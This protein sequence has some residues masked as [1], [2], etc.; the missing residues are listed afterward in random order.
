MATNDNIIAIVQ[1]IINDIRAEAIIADLVENG[2]EK[3]KIIIHPK[4]TFKRRYSRDIDSIKK[5]KLENSQELLGIY[6]HRDGLYDMLP[7]G[8]FHERSEKKVGEKDSRLKDSKES[9]KLK[10]E[11]KAARK[12][13]L[14]FE[15]EIMHQRVELELEERKILSRFSENLFNEI[16]PELW[17]L[18]K[19]LHRKYVY[20]MALLLHFAHKIAGNLQLTAR[21]LESIIDEEVKIKLIRNSERNLTEIKNSKTKKVN[22][23]LGKNELGVDFVCGEQFEDY[24]KTME[25]SIGPLKNTKVSEYLEN[26]VLSKF[27]TCFFGYFVPVD[28]D[29]ES[30]IIVDPFK[31]GFEL[32]ETKGNSILGFETSI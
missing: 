26:G 17:D 20:K 11:E 31:Q 16:Y 19:S 1:N 12:F 9:K 5:V 28:F 2:I 22:C 27:L 23:L 24:G 18:H 29:V 14:P 25:F 4:G 30:K 3:D 10:Q 6:L 13:F 15:H 21:C 7:E 32:N 8:L